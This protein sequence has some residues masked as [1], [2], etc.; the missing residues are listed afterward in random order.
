MGDEI[1]FGLNQGVAVLEVIEVRGDTLALFVTLIDDGLENLGLHFSGCAEIVV[2]ANLDPVD[3]HLAVG[4]DFGPYFLGRIAR[5]DVA[6]HEEA[7][8]IE[9]RGVL[10][11]TYFDR[12]RTVAAQTVDRGDAVT[13]VEPELIEDVFLGVDFLAGFESSSSPHMPVAVDETRL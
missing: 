11:V 7:R 13:G 1:H 3:P 9:V 6:G 5:D 8:S 4:I 2:D 12:R 10:G